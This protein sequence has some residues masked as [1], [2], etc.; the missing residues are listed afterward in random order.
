M[1]FRLKRQLKF[2][3]KVWILGWLGEKLLQDVGCGHSAEDSDAG[4]I[5]QRAKRQTLRKFKLS[6]Y[7]IFL[8][9][10]DPP[11]GKSVYASNSN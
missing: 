3:V 5:Y 8:Y 6:N 1:Q 10:E 7:T 9:W 11:H 4:V 2:S